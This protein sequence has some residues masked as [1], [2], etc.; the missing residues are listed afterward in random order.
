[1]SIN[2]KEEKSSKGEMKRR[3]EVRP[4]LKKRRSWKIEMGSI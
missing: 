4:R 1:V 2:W 3:G